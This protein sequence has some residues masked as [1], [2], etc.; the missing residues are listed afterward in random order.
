MFVLTEDPIDLAEIE[1]GV[2]RHENGGL[3][4]FMGTVRSPSQGRPVQF[5]EYEAYR[6][7]AEREMERIAEKVCEKWGVRHLAIVHR[8]GRVAVGEAAVVVAAAS[9]HRRQ[10]FEACQYAMDRVK[11]AVPIWK[12][13]YF[14]EGPSWSSGNLSSP[15]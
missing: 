15:E 8:V 5:I 14:P 2:R 1:Q 9:P 6:G 12:K 7:M 11:E 10:A 4:I 3:V 13:E